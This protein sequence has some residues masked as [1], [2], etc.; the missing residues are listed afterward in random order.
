MAG[1]LDFCA[2]VGICRLLFRERKL[3]VR[4]RFELHF[5]SGFEAL[6]KRLFSQYE[7]VWFVNDAV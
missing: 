7:C 1:V 5:N 2:I 4:G 3:G 6:T